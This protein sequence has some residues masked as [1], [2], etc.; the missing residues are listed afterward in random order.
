MNQSRIREKPLSDE[1][2]WQGLKH[3]L[4]SGYRTVSIDEDEIV[5]LKKF[6]PDNFC[7]DIYKL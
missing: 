4:Y 1:G 3:K 2:C 7:R 6:L 5:Y